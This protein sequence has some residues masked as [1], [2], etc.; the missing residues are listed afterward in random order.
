MRVKSDP[1]A[2]TFGEVP[3]NSN[4]RIRFVAKR[5]SSRPKVDTTSMATA[6]PSFAVW[7]TGGRMAVCE[8]E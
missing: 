6:S 1:E 7:K 4:L 5:P 2:T 8:S 3:F